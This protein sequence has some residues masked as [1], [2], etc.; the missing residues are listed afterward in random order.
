MSISL[1]GLKCEIPNDYR[2]SLL[3]KAKRVTKISLFRYYAKL[4]KSS[5]LIKISPAFFSPA[6]LFTEFEFNRAIIEIFKEI[7]EISPI[8]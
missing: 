1:S 3:K 2:Y 5:F 4:L 6:D 8:G 7:Y